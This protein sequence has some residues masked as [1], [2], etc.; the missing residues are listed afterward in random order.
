MFR[1]IITVPAAFCACLT[2]NV[3]PAGAQDAQPGEDAF[4]FKDRLTQDWGG[5]R[6]TLAE[7]GV[8][9]QL[10]DQNEFWAIPVGGSQPSNN[11][12]GVTTASSRWI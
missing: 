9:F 12:I 3:A 6:R 11:Y 7:H 2:L 8:D 1:K 4:S 5:V 10:T